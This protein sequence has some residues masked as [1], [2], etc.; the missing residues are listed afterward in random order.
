M[1][2]VSYTGLRL[3]SGDVIVSDAE[4][5]DI[6]LDETPEAL[7][8]SVEEQLSDFGQDAEM[9][10]I[11]AVTQ[12]VHERYDHPGELADDQEIYGDRRE[13]LGDVLVACNEVKGDI[14][15]SRVYETRI[16]SCREKTAIQVLAL[17]QLG[18][19]AMY[20]E[21]YFVDEKGE[22]FGHAW[23]LSSNYDILDASANRILES[24]HDEEVAYRAGGV[25]K[26]SSSTRARV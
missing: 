23:G 21:G 7:V 6:V 2:T 13:K 14:R 9:E 20:A 17:N 8:E 1:A 15:L 16:A 18:A 26:Q 24:N 10:A 12:E 19:D 22:S 4:V 3:Q 11:E 5:P 25:M